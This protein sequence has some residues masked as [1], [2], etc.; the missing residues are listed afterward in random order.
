MLFQFETFF[1]IFQSILPKTQLRKRR[2]VVVAAVD[3]FPSQYQ[4]RTSV[5]H[6]IA[7]LK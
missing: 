7:V 2:P 6:V 3:N 5:D 1:R 4:K